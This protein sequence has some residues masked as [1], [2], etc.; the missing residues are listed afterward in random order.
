[1]KKVLAVI[2]SVAMIMA[3]L[4]AAAFAETAE[5]DHTISHG[6]EEASIAGTIERADWVG[7]DGCT[8]VA[9]GDT[10]TFSGIVD[11]VPEDNNSAG[12]RI[13]V[14]IRKPESFTADSDVKV[15]MRDIEHTWT[16]DRGDTFGLFPNI[17]EKGESIEIKV[18]WTENDSQVF[19]IK[20]ADDIILEAGPV[21]QIQKED[22]TLGN[23][24]NSLQEAIDAAGEEDTVKIISNPVTLNKPIVIDQKRL[25]L[26][27]TSS[28]ARIYA[29]ANFEGDCLFEVRNP[30]FVKFN[31]MI[32]DGKQKAK[33]GV[34]ATATAG[35]AAVHFS[36][37]IFKNCLE[38]GVDTEN[39]IVYLMFVQTDG[40]NR[41]GGVHISKTLENMYAFICTR[42][43][44]IKEEKQFAVGEEFNKYKPISHDTGYWD[45]VIS[46]FEPEHTDGSNKWEKGSDGIYTEKAVDR[47]YI[48]Y[49]GDLE[50][51][52]ISGVAYENDT[53]RRIIIAEQEGTITFKVKSLAEGLT[54][55]AVKSGVITDSLD[56]VEYI[57]NE[58]N[59]S[60][61]STGVVSITLNLKKDRAYI[62]DDKYADSVALIQKEDGTV[63]G[64][65][66]SLQE[67]IDAAGEKD[68]V[69][70]ISNN[71]TLEKPLVIDGKPVR[72]WQNNY[73]RIKASKDFTG[74]SMIVVKNGGCL[75]AGEIHLDGQN[76]AQYGI[77][78]I[79][80]EYR[81]AIDL[82][83]CSFRNFT[84]YGA[85]LDCCDAALKYCEFEY[86]NGE[87]GV[88][89]ISGTTGGD[90]TEVGLIGCKFKDIV[91][92]DDF[93][94]YKPVQDWDM[95]VADF[96]PEH[97]E[98]YIS[99]EKGADGIYREKG[100]PEQFNSRIQQLTELINE[101]KAAAK[102]YSD[103]KYR[104]SYKPEDELV[105]SGNAGMVFYLDE[106]GA[107]Q[108]S[109]ASKYPVYQ[110]TGLN[111]TQT[112]YQ[113]VTNMLKQQE[114]L[115]AIA[116]PEYMADETGYGIIEAAEKTL[117]DVINGHDATDSENYEAAAVE[118]CNA[119]ISGSKTGGKPGEEITVELNI[120][121][122]PGIASMLLEIEYDRHSL[123]FI[124]AE[125]GEI[126]SNE[127]F[128]APENTS[129]DAKILLWQ[130][131]TITDN[132]ST[133]GRLAVLRFKIKENA[134][135]G[136]TMINIICDCDK[137]Q[138]IDIWGASVE[139]ELDA[140]A[141][142]I[143]EF[144]YGDVDNDGSVGITDVLLLRRYL[145]KWN[146]YNLAETRAADLDGDETV[147]LRDVTILER[148]IAGW[149]GYKEPP[150]K[151]EI[152]PV[153]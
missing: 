90:G 92:E 48:S 147:T 46:D 128:L 140:A 3:M 16:K 116:G 78:T 21:A 44:V 65:Y 87:G 100:D 39:V 117:K 83:N 98:G 30:E 113:L 110:L 9:D 81:A 27:N 6:A 47:S 136:E 14:I 79:S 62:L 120:D 91:F 146:G 126:F 5:Y 101:Y 57:T 12:N 123:E 142:N 37:C 72:L 102:K 148:H 24:Y 15:T 127:S 17:T 103:N 150:V 40:S 1:M 124:S 2:L 135:P 139:A 109:N 111:T 32:I 20:A 99:W 125:N 53:N 94:R 96:E 132:I 71:I 86:L 130:N 121:V 45:M 61:D 54:S 28:V 66:N 36:S 18:D 52:D 119:V 104:K 11:Y 151:Q 112:A 43:S 55:I 74:Q 7:G 114:K 23:T 33:Y 76:I 153:L 75:A 107:L 106:Q 35:E 63:S 67:A 131:S 89:L 8:A 4:P 115:L 133:T 42:E 73:I 49:S 134:Q 60:A 137:N 84:E 29:G 56:D 149:K 10:I 59:F 88:H 58:G 69:R 152:L 138:V 82:D 118:M 129:A 141:V 145:A 143:R 41:K 51:S 122:N 93:N 50:I 144:T 80:E 13:G 19:V 77:Q 22:G 68:N 34:K 97:T 26:S 31:G 25:R 105:V 108:C 64:S 95:I 85:V 38:Y 70:I